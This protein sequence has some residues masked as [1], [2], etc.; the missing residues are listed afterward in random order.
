MYFSTGVS[1]CFW[2]YAVVVKNFSFFFVIN[3][4]TN[5]G[6]YPLFEAKVFSNNSLLKFAVESGIES[7]L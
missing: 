7:S 5:L 4:S 1:R 6:L 2:L 3:R